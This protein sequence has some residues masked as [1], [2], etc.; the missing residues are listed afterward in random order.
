MTTLAPRPAPDTAAASGTSGTLGT[1]LPRLDAIRNVPRAFDRLADGVA[2]VQDAARAAGAR[3]AVS[4]RCTVQRANHRHLRT[5]V[6]AARDIGL[7]RVSFLAADVSS[8]AF[9]RPDG[10]DG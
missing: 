7:D 1:P 10:W 8:D 2:A 5:T 4:A 6:D 9:N 3:V